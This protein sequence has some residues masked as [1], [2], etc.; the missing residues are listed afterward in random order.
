MK[1][2]E[3]HNS[4]E[5]AVCLNILF[6]FFLNITLIST[7]NFLGVIFVQTL[8]IIHFRETFADVFPN[9]LSLEM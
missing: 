6:S 7:Y 8:A 5:E 9:G 3:I 1:A 4:E 2:L